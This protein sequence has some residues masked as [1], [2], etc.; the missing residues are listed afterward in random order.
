ML[1]VVAGFKLVLFE[2]ENVERK[3]IKKESKTT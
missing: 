1:L 3:S 2:K